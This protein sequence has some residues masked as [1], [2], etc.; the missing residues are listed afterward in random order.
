M[1]GRA[2]ERGVLGRVRGELKGFLEGF[3]RRGAG[4]TCGVGLAV[5]CIG[6][7]V[8]VR[9]EVDEEV[10]VCADAV[11]AEGRVGIGGG[12]YAVCTG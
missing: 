3:T 4:F 12:V 11:V 9:E 10:G 5:E 7:G 6:I 2:R 1:R 8:R